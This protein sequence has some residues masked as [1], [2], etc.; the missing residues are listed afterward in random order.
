ML[1]KSCKK[2]S[3]DPAFYNLGVTINFQ[4]L[5]HY[6]LSFA[7]YLQQVLKLKKGDRV[8]IMM[9]NVLQYPVAILGI[10]RAGLIVVNVNPLY[11]APELIH[12]LKDAEATTIVVLSNFM[13]TVEQA[14]PKTSLKNII[15]TDVGDLFPQP[16]AWL[17]NFYLKYIKKQIP[18]CHLPETISF[19]LALKEGEKLSFEKVD[20]T[21]N[22]IA[23]LQYTGGT[24]GISKG[25]MLTHRNIVANI[26]QA[27]AWFS[28]EFKAETE[29]MITALP[30]YHIFSLTGNGLFMM[31]IGGLN[32]LITNPRDMN[33]LFEIG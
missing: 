8:A 5:D 12:Q 18:K 25:A 2:F 33:R 4:Q 3:Q 19:K 1:D 26:L 31:K 11:T 9:P 17:V 27:E 7:T 14:L 6:A 13:Q 10:L 21:L 28:P 23:F 30:L 29:I 20:I 15:I 32:V 24:T 22:D 16:K